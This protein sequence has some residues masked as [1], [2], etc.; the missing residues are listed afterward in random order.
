M[1]G[2]TTHNKCVCGCQQVIIPLGFAL[3]ALL[4]SLASYPASVFVLSSDWSLPGRDYVAG[5]AVY[6]DRT[7]GGPGVGVF[8]DG[9]PFNRTE[10]R[11]PRYVFVWKTWGKDDL[12]LVVET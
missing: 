2:R 1:P 6:A 10:D 3:R 4:P 9:S 12:K 5:Q 11:R 8:P 7:A